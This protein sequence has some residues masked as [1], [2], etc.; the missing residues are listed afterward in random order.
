LDR[1]NTEAR[2]QL[3]EMYEVSDRRE[4]ALQL[5]NEVLALKRIDEGLP[6][7]IDPALTAAGPQD[8]T[9]LFIQQPVRAAGRTRRAALTAEQK[10][11]LEKRK[12]ESTLVKFKKLEVLQKG[13]EAGEEAAV[14]EW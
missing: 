6:I 5:V 14:K 7:P 2:M 1:D 10:A 9:A 13:M 3:A 11:A 12:E 8:D 4:E